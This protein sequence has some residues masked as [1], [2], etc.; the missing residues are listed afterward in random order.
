MAWCDPHPCAGSHFKLFSFEAIR[1][2]IFERFNGKNNAIPGLPS[3]QSFGS[4]DPH[5]SLLGAPNP[6]GFDQPSQFFTNLSAWVS[7]N[8][9]SSY[10]TFA[11]N[12]PGPEMNPSS[13][14]GA[15]SIDPAIVHS[16]GY[17]FAQCLNSIVSNDPGCTPP[18]TTIGIPNMR[19]I[20]KGDLKYDADGNIDPSD[21]KLDEVIATEQFQELGP[22]AVEYIAAFIKFYAPKVSVTAP[23]TA[24]GSGWLKGPDL[25]NGAACQLSSDS[26]ELPCSFIVVHGSTNVQ[27]EATAAAGSVFISWGG[28]CSNAI[29][30][31]DPNGANSILTLDTINHD[32]NCT[33][34]FGKKLVVTVRG[35]GSVTSDPP[36]P[37]TGCTSECTGFFSGSVKLTA[38]SMATWKQDCSGSAA[39]TTVVLDA[40]KT[41]D[42]IFPGG[43]L[44]IDKGS[45]GMVTS[46]PAGISC[47]EGCMTTSSFFDG[48]VTLTAS[49]ASSFV[50]WSG[51]CSGTAPTTTVNVEMDQSCTAIFQ[52]DIAGVRLNPSGHISFS[53][54]PG[55]YKAEA[56]DSQLNPVV[57]SQDITVTLG[58]N[59]TSGCNGL[60]FSALRRN[61]N[62]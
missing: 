42:V 5:I 2:E 37:I 7:T 18:T 56:V 26:S 60:L 11:S 57:V 35:N 52:Q 21:A 45:I 58:R 41:C 15:W 16:D 48:T 47:S 54:N 31:V 22:I 38:S 30:T 19:K 61:V 8:F 3:A 51:S 46:V 55:P 20:A 9:F 36:S 1:C 6:W 10:S 13:T 59:V 24:S 23:M 39:F 40:D 62:G 33:A 50:Q 44:T 34:M 4:S 29:Y 43:N 12:L 53:S 32:I 17:F 14:P 25:S 49:P 28:D 27:L